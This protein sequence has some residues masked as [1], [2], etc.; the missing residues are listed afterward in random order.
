MFKRLFCNH[1]NHGHEERIHGA[2]EDEPGG[3][4]SMHYISWV[5]RGCGRVLGDP[6]DRNDRAPDIVPPSGYMWRRLGEVWRMV[7]DTCG[8]NCGQCGITG[9][10]GNAPVDLEHMIVATSMNNPV[11]G[12]RR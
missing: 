5:C 6:L 12:L 2:F 8:G 9:K 10:I 1:R 3:P 11:H 4:R 7:C